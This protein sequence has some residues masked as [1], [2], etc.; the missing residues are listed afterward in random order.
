MKYI[1]ITFYTEGKEIDGCYDLR[2]E[3]KE[4]KKIV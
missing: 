4:Y 3:E 1:F 2:K